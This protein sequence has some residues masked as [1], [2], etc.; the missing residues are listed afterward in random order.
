MDYKEL[1]KNKKDLALILILIIAFVLRIIYFNINSAIW[2]DEAEYIVMAKDFA[3]SPAWA[4]WNAVRPLLLPMIWAVFFKI[5]L[6]E[7]SIR[8]FTEFLPSFALVLLIYLLGTE[9]YNKKIG[10]ISSFIYSMFWLSLFLTG[11]LLTDQISILFAFLSVYYFWKGYIKKQKNLYIYLSGIFMIVGILFRFPTGVIVVP[12]ILFLLVRDRLNVIKNKQIWYSILSV[13]ILLV[14]YVI[15][16]LVKFGSPF[17]AFKFYVVNEATSAIHQFSSPAYYILQYTLLY[18]ESLFLAFFLLGFVLILINVVFGFDMI[19]KQENKK[20]NKDFFILLWI[21]IPFLFF[22]FIYKYA[23]PRYLL[24]TIAPI[25]FVTSKGILAVYDYIKKYNKQIA[26]VI[27]F[28][29]LI[30]GAFQQYNHTKQIV[31]AKK[32]TYLQIKQAALWIKDN[33]PPDTKVHITAN[34][35]EFLAYAERKTSNGVGNNE[36]DFYERMK[37]LDPDYLIVSYWYQ[38]EV[39]YPDW[40]ISILQNNPERYQPIGAYFMNEEKT[41]PGAIIL[42][43]NKEIQEK[44]SYI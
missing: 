23:E 10:L 32:D 33:T 12:P 42:K 36:T 43:I 21:L 28:V 40:F 25:L 22:I 1:L 19:I 14:P 3:F 31:D 16:N 2:W 39:A 18:L 27:L 38:K 35:M 17:P 29:I 24:M 26:V 37:T 44:T 13:I 34:Q 4:D 6:G 20:Y 5:G 15:W 30:F 9:I 8:F 11:R 41:I 7:T